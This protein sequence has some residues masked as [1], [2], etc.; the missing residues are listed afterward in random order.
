MSSAERLDQLGDD[1]FALVHTLDPFTATELGVPGFDGLV[2]DPSRDGAA[3][4]AAGIADI[5]RRLADIDLTAL[6]EAGVINAAVLGHLAG[7]ARSDLE[8]GL[9][10]ANA[11]ADGYVSPAAAMIRS[12]TPSP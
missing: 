8:H 12:P 10:E 5:E 9:W 3:R 6:D 1:Y 11:S 4:G 7:A 2:P